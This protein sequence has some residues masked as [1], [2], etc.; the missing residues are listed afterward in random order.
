MTIKKLVGLLSITLLAGQLAVAEMADTPVEAK[1]DSPTQYIVKPGDSLWK[2][3]DLFLKDPWRWPGIWQN[4]AQIEN[5]HLIYPGDIIALVQTSDG[6]RLVVN[7]AKN[8]DLKLTPTVLSEPVDQSIPMIPLYEIAQFLE[9]STVVNSADRSA[10]P[11][12]LSGV[13]EHVISGAGDRIYVRKLPDGDDFDV[14]RIGAPYIDPATNE[15]L[16]LAA[17][18]IGRTSLVENGDPAKLLITQSK[19]EI[20]PGDI[21]LPR[22]N[23]LIE[24]NFNPRPADASVA[25]RIID[26]VDG[27]SQIGQYNVVV[28]NRGSVDGI[29]PGHTLRVFKSPGDLYDS[30][31][32]EWVALPDEQAGTLLVFKSFERVSFG[33]ITSSKAAIEVNDKAIGGAG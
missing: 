14:F 25:T 33:L 29:E 16:G 9:Q 15:Q 12:V 21:L 18:Y 32:K 17:L 20:L 28:I 4:N 22:N 24:P 27:V 13:G 3:A 11:Y 19:R 7:P 31:A 8:G 1:L 5:P 2:I 10:Y 6:L 23:D 26:V 30:N